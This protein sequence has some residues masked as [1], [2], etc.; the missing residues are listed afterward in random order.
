M[1][2]NTRAAVSPRISREIRVLSFWGMVAVV[3]GHAYNYTDSFLLPTTRIAEGMQIG[4]MI[5]FFFS[6]AMVKFCTPV[7]FTISGYLLFASVEH[8]TLSVYLEKIRGRLR[9]L[10]VPYLFWVL[11]WTGMGMLL[12]KAFGNETFPIL[13]EKLGDSPERALESIYFHP[14]PFQFWYIKDLLIL[15][16]LS[17]LFYLLVVG[18]KGFSVLIFLV[19]WLMNI[20]APYLTSMEGPL[21]FTFGVFLAM[22]GARSGLLSDT[23]PRPRKWMLCISFCWT[24]ACAAYTLISAMISSHPVADLTLFIMCRLS[25]ILGVCSV[26]ILVDFFYGQEQDERKIPSSSFLLFALHEPLQHMI[27]QRI[28]SNGGPDSLHL[29]LYFGLP[30]VLVLLLNGLTRILKQHLPKFHA[31]VTG[32]R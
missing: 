3:L 22:H 31:F 4:P 30:V 26:F 8:F 25:T 1:T 29:L 28:L 24:G 2:K 16:L 15:S 5:E 20:S 14:L 6:N 18:L 12:M 21:F 17:P 13:L 27:Y 7:F 32:G 11:L 10:V 9:S 19:L 23:R